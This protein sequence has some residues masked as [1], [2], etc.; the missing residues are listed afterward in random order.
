M[1]HGRRNVDTLRLFTKLLF[2]FLLL[3]NN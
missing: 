2:L 1:L 3:K